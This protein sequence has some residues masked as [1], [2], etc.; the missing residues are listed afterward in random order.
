VRTATQHSSLRVRL[1]ARE[2]LQQLESEKLSRLR[3]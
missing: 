3:R 1:K 2:V